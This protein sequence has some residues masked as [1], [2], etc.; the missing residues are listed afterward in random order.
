MRFPIHAKNANNSD[1]NKKP[2]VVF[3]VV[4]F[5]VL[6]IHLIKDLV[7]EHAQAQKEECDQDEKENHCDEVT[8][9]GVVEENHSGG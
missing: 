2:P 9:G 7:A 3:V 5:F 6:V 8:D 1:K 4:L